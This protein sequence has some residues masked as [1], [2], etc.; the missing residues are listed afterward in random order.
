M[1]IDHIGI[2][3][4]AMEAGIEQW[5]SLFGY[6]QITEKVTNTRQQVNVVFMEKP[7]SITIKLIEPVDQ[8]SPIYHFALKGGGL[9]HICFKCDNVD[10]AVECF[11]EKGMRILSEPQPGEAFNNEKIAFVYAKQ[12]LNVELIDT[13]AKANRIVL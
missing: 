7:D 11:R 4:K 12:G 13:L 8:H 10:K 2:V 1:I 9:H 5:K 6:S 3:V